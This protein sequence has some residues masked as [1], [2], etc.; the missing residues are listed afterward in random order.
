M[1]RSSLKNVARL[2]DI[3]NKNI[4]AEESFLAD[5][6]RSIEITA[7]SDNG[8]PSKTLKPS[9][10]NC[11]R[12]SY[13]QV[14]GI[15]PDDGESTFNMIGICNAGT[16]IHVRVQTAVI[17]MK[18]NGMD[19]EWVDVEE[20]V[21][22]RGL[23]YLEI[24]SKTGTETKL[25]DTRYNISFMCD[26]IVRYKGKYYILEFKTETSNKWY[27]RTG[28][29]PKHYHQ[30]MS[31]SNS[32]QLND[33]LFVYIDRDMLNMKAYMFSVTDKMRQEIVD[34]ATDVAGYVER[35]VVPP[36]RA[37]ASSQ[38]CRYCGYQMQCK[39]DG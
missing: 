21:K 9:G 8:L 28:V 17:Q 23:D 22:S 19:C 33:V 37:D 29:D 20:F 12:G 10:M 25:Y 24:R 4:P 13:Y 15:K 1:A 2:I 16:D 27:T 30:A 18:K 11:M 3:S 26:G 6:K 7:N 5:L 38:K 35:Q 36:K 39:K 31:Y 14:M 34:Y 32:L